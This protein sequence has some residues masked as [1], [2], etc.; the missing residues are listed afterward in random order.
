MSLLQ[1]GFSRFR[2]LDAISQRTGRGGI[3]GVA[4]DFFF[5]QDRIASFLKEAK[6]L[7]PMSLFYGVSACVG[8]EKYNVKR[9]MDGN[10]ESWR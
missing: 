6:C 5:S 8:G 9:D 2:C 1:F 7:L 4:I 10:E 3:I